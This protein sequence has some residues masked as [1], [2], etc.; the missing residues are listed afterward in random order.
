MTVSV[1]YIVE[2][3][4][5]AIDFYRDLLGFEVDMHPAPGFARLT[6]GDLVLLLNEPGVGGAGQ[7]GGDPQP[8]GWSRFQ[9]ETDDLDREVTSLRQADAAF[10][11]EMVEG[12][13]GRQI[14]IEDPSGNL[15]EL[16][17]SG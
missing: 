2:N 1:R 16:F 8:G 13:G 10:R 17:E 12:R 3:V 15:V 7:A 5:E 14:L 9:I 11:G 4:D 6:R